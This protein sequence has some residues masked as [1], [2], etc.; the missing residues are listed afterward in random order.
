MKQL[1]INAEAVSYTISH[2][3]FLS[4]VGRDREVAF[5]GEQ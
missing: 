5:Y 4:F 1:C 3:V 2:P